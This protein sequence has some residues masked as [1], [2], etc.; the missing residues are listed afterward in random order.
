M[1][2]LDPGIL[3]IDG[4]S[5]ERGGVETERLRQAD[6]PGIGGQLQASVIREYVAMIERLITNCP[7]ASL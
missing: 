2:C 7:M 6:Q 4:Q 5:Q 1:H 3:S